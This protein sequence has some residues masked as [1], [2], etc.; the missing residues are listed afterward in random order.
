MNFGILYAHFGTVTQCLVEPKVPKCAHEIP[1]FIKH[2]AKVHETP[3]ITDEKSIYAWGIAIS[4]LN[5]WWI[6]GILC[7]HFG[8]VTQCSVDRRAVQ[9][10]IPW[11]KKREKQQFFWKRWTMKKAYLSLLTFLRG[12]II[13]Q[14]YSW[15]FRQKTESYCL[16]KIVVSIVLWNK[17]ILVL[18]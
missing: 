3:L 12:S 5:F 8:T 9:Y 7:T 11:Q 17:V 4:G 14:G 2:S 10:R 18:E 6:F 13:G 16:S 15:L 1:T